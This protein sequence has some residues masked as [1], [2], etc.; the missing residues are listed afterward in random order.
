MGYIQNN[1]NPGE[2]ILYAT[3]LHWI[4]LMRSI[5]VDTVF[6]GAGI[7]L[8]VWAVAGKHPEHGEAQMAGWVGFALI[9]FG[10]LILAIDVIRRNATEMA[11]T[12]KRI[13]IKVGFLTKRTVELFLSRVESVSVEQTLAGRMMGYG[14][15]AVRGTGGTNEP[16]SH[17]AN[18]LEFR[19]QVQ[20][21]IEEHLNP[22]PEAQ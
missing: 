22:S 6:S 14:S 17:V 1:L 3:H 4:V 13:I 5:L 2:R 8:M 11:V 15:I 21:Q 16:F 9:L 10:S 19:R 7:A 20:H 18:P 12:N